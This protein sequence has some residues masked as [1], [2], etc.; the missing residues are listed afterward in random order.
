MKLFYLLILLCYHIL[1]L[2]NLIFEFPRFHLKS[3]SLLFA[4][5]VII[6]KLAKFLLLLLP[7]LLNLLFQALNDASLLINF[8]F[9]GFEGHFKRSYLLL[10]LIFLVIFLKAL[11][12]LELLN[13]TIMIM[14]H[15]MQIFFMLVLNT[16]YCLFMLFF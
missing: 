9:L 3:F 12:Y 1:H 13:F 2:T 7:F 10:I 6:S 16:H 4:I 8:F 11:T 15:C 14:L 5:L